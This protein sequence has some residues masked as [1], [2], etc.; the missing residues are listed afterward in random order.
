LKRSEAL[1]CAHHASTLSV[2]YVLFV[3]G[4]RIGTTGG[5]L[6]HYDDDFLSSYE[7]CIDD[8][9]EASLK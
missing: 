5:V 6:I 4:D 3:I 2:N 9:Y 1:Q 8:A 7:Q